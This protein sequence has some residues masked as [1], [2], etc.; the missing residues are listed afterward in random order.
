MMD[1]ALRALRQADFDWTLRIQQ[2][3]SENVRDIPEIQ[4]S[5]RD[6]LEDRLDMLFE[7]RDDASPLGIP[8]VGPAG[9]GKTHLLGSL[10]AYAMQRGSFFVLVDMTDVADFWDTILLGY[11]R[12]LQQSS[13]DGRRQ[14]DAWLDLIV[15]K[16]GESVRKRA[17]IPKQRPPGLIVTTNQ[18]VESIRTEHRAAAAE[19]Q[20]VLRALVLFACDDADLNDMGYK[21]LQ[22][23]GIDEEEREHHGFH[24][25]QRTASQI[26]TGLSWALGLVAPTVLALDQLDAIV[27][28]HHSASR[29][30]LEDPNEQQLRSHAIIQGIAGG[31]LALRD[32]TMRT[33]IIV[34]SLEATWRLLGERAVVSMTDRFEPQLFMKPTSS[35]DLLRQLILSRLAD[36]Y[37]RFQLNPPYAGHPFRPEFFEHYKEESPRKLLQLCYQHVQLCKQ[38]DRVIELGTRA[39]ID[40]KPLP[41]VDPERLRAIT[42]KFEQLRA[43][44]ELP[45]LLEDESE[46][47]QDEVLEFASDALVVENQVRDAVH[48]QV[49][50]DFMGTGSYAPLH[51][52][53]RCILTDDGERE[54]HHA[55]RFLEKAHFRAFQARIKAAITASGI[56]H[57]LSFRGL[58]IVRVAPP[59]SGKATSKLVDELKS[60]GGHLLSPS[61]SDLRTLWAVA[62]LLKDQE[63][64][65]GD[66]LIEEWLRQKRPISKL[67]GFEPIVKTLFAGLAPSETVE[68]SNSTKPPA[69]LV[70]PF[71]QNAPAPAQPHPAPSPAAA[72]IVPSAPSNPTPSIAEPAPLSPSTTVSP[73]ATMQ[74]R[75]PVGSVWSSAAPGDVVDLPLGALANHTCVLAGAGSGKTVFLKRIVEEAA[76]LGVP[77][78]V[79]DGA[80]DLARLGEPWPSQPTDFTP[81]D[82]EKATRYHARTEVVVWTPGHALGNPLEL[83]LLPDFSALGEGRSEEGKAELQ[84]AI[85]MATS[86]LLPLVAP[87]TGEKV[88]KSEA[89]LQGA[90]QH[91]ARMKGGKVIDLVG[92]LREPPDDVIEPFN[93]GAKMAQNMA[94]LLY[95][96]IKTDPLLGGHGTVMDPGVLL[97]GPNGK[98]RVSV[99]N[100]CGLQGL[101]RQRQFIDRLATTLFT[102]IKKHPAPK[103]SLLGLF[104][105]DEAKDFVPSGANVPGKENI[106]RLAAQA[107][108]YGLGLLFATQAP[109]S[110]DHKAV[111]N[112]ST[113][114]VGRAN[115]PAAI[116]TVQELLKDKGGTANDVA[117]LDRGTFYFTTAPERPRKI[118]TSLCLSYHPSSP[119]SETEVVE[120]A[121]KSRP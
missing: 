52:R 120:M 101:D 17:D 53:I 14:V 76:L 118:A 110:I 116:D 113:L 99:I 75:L 34:S 106:I 43:N 108:K 87:G 98:T 1:N 22:G 12:S 30:D 103:N 59:P 65:K 45:A 31:L 70:T 13:T 10:R 115:S 117:K 9:S 16:Y 95:S 25:A 112:C 42:R 121:R 28:E 107:R 18:L 51:A 63:E 96:A 3:W 56:D 50:K 89:I 73:V 91:F 49:D 20:D 85:A 41:V 84:A 46:D 74:S 32:V 68:T 100:L 82:V 35:A 86:S 67:P 54:R 104:V 7:K 97:K 40:E 57:D 2:V 58:T 92:L 26:V 15:Q 80:N 24:V 88:R 8:L 119:P 4:R 71:T 114:L 48:P 33:L 79:I 38:H 72:A 11:L 69:A 83:D 6:E 55:F 5:I 60:R 44:A 23:I 77:S 37:A 36:S 21:W 102:Y 93:N 109:K 29:A 81:G 94:E 78:I 105:L 27:A 90:L 39:F 62:R 66:S 61:E 47:L 111:A 19:H 64:G